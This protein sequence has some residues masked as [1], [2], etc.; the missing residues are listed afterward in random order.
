LCSRAIQPVKDVLKGGIS[1]NELA[2]S[3]A[4][5]L[6][7]GIWPV[8]GTQFVICFAL[9]FLLSGTAWGGGNI[10]IFQAINCFLTPVELAL[11]PFHVWVGE[12]V[13]RSPD[14]F[15]S[16]ALISGLQT[17]LFGTLR[18]AQVALFRAVVGWC[19]VAP[20]L[21]AAVLYGVPPLVRYRR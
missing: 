1:P 11:I 19:C 5:G 6:A 12:A 15:Q 2:S 16:S 21:L 17:D 13:L 14:A 4:I 8:C 7:G 20:V 18:T 10:V 3:V 9:Q